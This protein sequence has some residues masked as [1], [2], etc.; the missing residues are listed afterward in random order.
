ML[1]F[2][3]LNSN[4]LILSNMG[5]KDHGINKGGGGINSYFLAFEDI[6]KLSALTFG[7]YIGNRGDS[8]RSSKLADL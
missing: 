1:E 4:N 2:Q 3:H 5:V 8:T 6:F 7:H